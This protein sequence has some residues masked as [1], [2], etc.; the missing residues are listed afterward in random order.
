MCLELDENVGHFTGFLNVFH[1]VGRDMYITTINT[2]YWKCCR[3]NTFNIYIVD[4]VAANTL[5]LQNVSGWKWNSL[6]ISLIHPPSAH[7]ASF[8]VSVNSF[9]HIVTHFS[10]SCANLQMT[11]GTWLWSWKPKFLYS[12]WA[13]EFFFQILVMIFSWTENVIVTCLSFTVVKPTGHQRHS[14]SMK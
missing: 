9:E 3:S 10:I 7:T 4:S 8:S 14:F 1:I 5:I 12:T 13:S 11:E 2:M 6:T